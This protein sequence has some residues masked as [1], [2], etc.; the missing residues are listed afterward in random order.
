MSR[1]EPTLAD[2]IARWSRRPVLA[3]PPADLVRPLLSFNQPASGRDGDVELLVA[4]NQGVWL[5]G[6]DASGRFVERENED[7]RPWRPTGEDETAFWLHH[8]AFEFLCGHFPAFRST[9]DQTEDVAAL[10][11]EATDPLPVGEWGWPGTR[12][13]LR[14]RGDSLAMLA[15]HGG[16][17]WLVVS[18]PDEDEL[19]WADALAITWDESDS[20]REHHE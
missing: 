17:F 20:W 7:G 1:P 18:G 6:R 5:W 10:V 14:H 19:T 4:E 8:A 2:W 13:R 16:L 9:T 3:G 15:D 12:Q 11:L